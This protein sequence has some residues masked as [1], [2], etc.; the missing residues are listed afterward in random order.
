[1][2]NVD[3]HQCL[4]QSYLTEND[5]DEERST[6]EALESQES[7]SKG[8][9]SHKVGEHGGFSH[10]ISRQPGSVM[11]AFHPYEPRHA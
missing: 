8:R 5:I 7:S 9:R 3:E 1:M 4:Y 2:T 11:L 6:P 10:D